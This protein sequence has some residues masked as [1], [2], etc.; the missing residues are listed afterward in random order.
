SSDSAWTASHLL[1]P[2]WM[3]ARSTPMPPS[4]LSS[5]ILTLLFS[6]N[7][8]K[9]TSFCASWYAPPHET[10]DRSRAPALAA[11]PRPNATISAANSTFFLIDL[12]SYCWFVLRTSPASKGENDC[13]RRGPVRDRG[14]T[15]LRDVCGVARRHVGDQ[16][17]GG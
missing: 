12:S 11:T 10:T 15:D 14:G 6:M 13:T 8:L 17:A 1:A 3:L 2:L 4:Q 9:Y 5:T 7:G 16:F